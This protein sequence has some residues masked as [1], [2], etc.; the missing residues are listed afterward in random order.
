LKKA[1]RGRR[2]RL[3]KNVAGR[4]ED[5]NLLLLTIFPKEKFIGRRRTG[6]DRHKE[7][8]GERTR[9]GRA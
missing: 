3:K 1:W 6:G 9:S 4:Q 7:G 2:V 8:R 5:A